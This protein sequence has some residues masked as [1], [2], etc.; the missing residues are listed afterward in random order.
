M[1]NKSGYSRAYALGCGLALTIGAGSA[2][3]AKTKEVAYFGDADL[4][5]VPYAGLVDGKDGFFYG[6]TQN[7]GTNGLGI[8]FKI[9]PHTGSEY[10]IHTFAGICCGSGDGSF[11][12]SSLLLRGGY[13]YGTTVA[14][15]TSCDCGTVYRIT[16]DGTETVL[17]AFGGGTDGAQPYGRLVA[18]KQGNLYGT[19]QHGGTGG[20]LGTV[21]KIAPDGTETVLYSFQGI[22]CG[23]NDGSFP[24]AGLMLAKDGYLYGTTLNGGSAS[25]LGTVFRISR[26]GKESVIYAFAGG[27]DGAHPQGGVTADLNG[28]L[29]GTTYGGGANGLG[30]AFQVKPDGTESV[31]HTFQGICCGGGDGSFPQGDMLYSRDGIFYGATAKGGTASDLGTIFAMAP[32]GEEVVVHAFNGA[33]K[34]GST[35]NGGLIEKGSALYGTTQGGG[36]LDGGEVFKIVL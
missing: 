28:N 24:Q 26:K 21:Y 31:L 27:N 35:P 29:Y 12:Q 8:V 34:D 32:D 36:F 2:W 18:D 25:D 5:L 7:G 22:C 9:E 30:T 16:P 6:T 33:P 10:V 17:H 1:R 23:A 14:G 4:G 13:L 3:A 15:G 20:N 11:P 19:T